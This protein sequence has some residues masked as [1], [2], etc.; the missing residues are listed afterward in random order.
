MGKLRKYQYM[1]PDTVITQKIVSKIHASVLLKYALSE[2]EIA[3]GEKNTEEKRKIINKKK[4]QFGETVVRVNKDIDALFQRIPQ[5]KSRE[6]LDDLRTDMLFCYFAYGF[7]PVEYFSF[8][9]E[10]KDRIFRESFLSDRQ[11]VLYRLKMNHTISAW[12]FEDKMKTYELYHDYYY[13]DAISIEKPDDFI[14]FQEYIHKHPIFVK[15]EVKLSL[16][17]SVGL[18]DSAKSNLTEK[19]L[20]D[21]LIKHGKTILEEKIEQSKELAAFNTS[22]V[23]TVRVVSFYTKHGVKV[24]FCTLRTGRPGAFVDN[25]GAGGIQAGIDYNTGVVY[26]DGFDELGGIYAIHPGSN[27]AFKGYRL[28]DWQDLQKLI[29]ELA[30]KVPK[31]KYIGWDMAHTKNGWVMV[32][33]NECCQVIAKQMIDGRGIKKDFQEMMADMEL[34]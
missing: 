11:R 16:G 18:V 23:N 22:S 4:E 15:K 31:I 17:Q 13:R 29:V 10:G 2:K 19:E 27:T 30:E 21:S 28:P 25:G 6:S 24:P 7:T 5:Y 33:G 3:N 9:L 1:I 32:E 26:S 8:S 14:K 34:N 20:F 12:I